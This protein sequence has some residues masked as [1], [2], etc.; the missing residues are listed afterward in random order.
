[1]KAM[2]LGF[3]CR[4]AF[5]GVIFSFCVVVPAKA[6]VLFDE[7]IK[8]TPVYPASNQEAHGCKVASYT[9][10]GPGVYKVREFMDP[11]QGREFFNRIDGVFSF[12]VHEGWELIFKEYKAGGKVVAGLA[13]YGVA[14]DNRFEFKAPARKFSGEIKICPPVKCSLADCSRYGAVTALR[15]EFSGG[16]SSTPTGK[17]P[18][19]GSNAGKG[20]LPRSQGIGGKFALNANGYGG[21]IEVSGAGASPTI[22]MYYDV[23]GKWETMTNVRY[24]EATGE[25][26][27]TRP[28]AGNPNF[29]NYRGK[30]SGNS[31]AGTFTD[32]NTPGKSFK[33]KADRR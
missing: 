9:I 2:E 29:Q 27:F 3:R 21:K 16:G 10:T 19:S 17:A 25:L 12:G 30:L 11:R 18:V 31:L 5:Y 28:W 13:P 6:G 32:N 8:W 4:A 33:W 23:T 22:R 1:M 15:V 7:T 20:S 24:N 26:S 14:M